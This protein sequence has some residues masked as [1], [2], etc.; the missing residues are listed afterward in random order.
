FAR[1]RLF[2]V[3]ADGL[4]RAHDDRL[5]GTLLTADQ[6]FGVGDHCSHVAVH[7]APV[8]GRG[9]VGV[10]HVRFGRPVW[11]AGDV[12]ARPGDDDAGTPGLDIAGGHRR[13]FAEQDAAACG[14]FGDRFAGRAAACR[15]VDR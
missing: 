1:R 4:A 10:V 15:I 6:V 13:A 8:V 9:R 2:A 7:G 11:A 5:A 14:E 3:A 12:R